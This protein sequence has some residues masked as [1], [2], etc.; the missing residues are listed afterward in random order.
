[1]AAPS[2]PS[3]PVALCLGGV[4]PSGGAGILRDALTVAAFGVL[5]MAVST[6]ETLQ[7]G[8]GCAHILPPAVDPVARLESLGPHLAGRWGVKLGL[9][10]LAE[11]DF[12]RL[13][14]SLRALAPPVRIWDPV[15]APSAGVGLHDGGDLRRM[16]RELFALG[17]WV[18][19]P[20]RGEAA[21]FAGLPP[22][23]I[24]TA[25]VEILAAPFLELGAVAVWL[26]GG[27]GAGDRVQDHWITANGIEALPTAPRLPG[28]RRG[29]GCTLA[30][31]WLAL[32]LLGR[33]PLPAAVEAADWLRAGW[34]Q[35]FAPGGAGRPQFLPRCAAP[36][37]M[38]P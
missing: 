21:A 22:E 19:A 35:A 20:N 7:N 13:A 2:A 23:A 4:D 34:N 24:Q 27:H 16:G 8:L 6:A 18:V 28:V 15:L 29:T 17:G 30:S 3:A 12:R 26:K 14:A 25:A 31:A 11:A 36:A 38:R 1:M 9:C 32:R 37:G 10:A 33:E 5:P